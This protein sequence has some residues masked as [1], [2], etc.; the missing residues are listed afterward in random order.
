VAEKSQ[1]VNVVQSGL[2]SNRKQGPLPDGHGDILLHRLGGLGG[3]AEGSA[4]ARRISLPSLT[5]NPPDIQPFV[6]I[7]STFVQLSPTHSSQSP[8]SVQS[9]SHIFCNASIGAL[10]L[11]VGSD[12]TGLI[13]EAIQCST[14]AS[15]H[16]TW[17]GVETVKRMGVEWEMSC[18]W[19]C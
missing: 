18:D 11:P 12:R 8:N 14:S 1:K 13:T 6:H 17:P 16:S 7:V 19:R 4:T 9:I 3:G 10:I 2:S 15:V 5:K